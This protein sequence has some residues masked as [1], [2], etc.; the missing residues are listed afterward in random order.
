MLDNVSSVGP[1]MIVF[2]SPDPV[3]TGKVL[4]KIVLNVLYH[5]PG[6]MVG[7]LERKVNEGTLSRV[8]HLRAPSTHLNNVLL[9][10]VWQ[11]AMPVRAKIVNILRESMKDHAIHLHQLKVLLPSRVWDHVAL[12]LYR[13][14][15]DLGAW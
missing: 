6:I 1:K 7:R 4:I 2:G 11:R 14:D 3:G 15:L 10:H 9:V 13:A 8:L 5:L 12:V